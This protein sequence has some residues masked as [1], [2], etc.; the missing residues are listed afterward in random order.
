MSSSAIGRMAR[1]LRPPR[2]D[3]G[4][5]LLEIMVGAGIMAT[6]TA[7]ATSGF[8]V[9]YNAVG[10]IDS[11]TQAQTALLVA[12]NKLD[13]EIRYAQRITVEGATTA[14]YSVTYAIPD[15][16]D[17]L[18]CIQLT[19]PK[20]GGAL[21]R[22]QWTRPTTLVTPTAAFTAVAN[23]LAPKVSGSTPFVVTAGSADS[24]KPFDTMEL[25]VTSAV[26]IGARGTTRTYDLTFT[27]LNTATSSISLK[28]LP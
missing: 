22:R 12:F 19:L 20:T 4:F 8:T 2:G 10:R 7:I 5:S 16:S 13:H 25:Q 9:M 11:A 1:R 23:G 15:G 3:G 17:Q 27:A 26:G 18:T 28:C 24:T 6:V 14:L 21:M